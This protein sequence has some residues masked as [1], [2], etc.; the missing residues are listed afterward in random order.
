MY[1]EFKEIEIQNFGSVG[2]IQFVLEPGIT[3]V[4]GVNLDNTNSE[5][6][7]SGKST[8]FSESFRWAIYG[9]TSRKISSDGVI[10][11]V[12]DGDCFVKLKSLIT[13]DSGNQFPVLIER[14]RNHT[15]H[16]NTVQ[17][18]VDGRDETR[19]K[20]ADTQKE[21]ET[22]FRLPITVF[23]C[24]YLM[25]QGMD[26]KFTSMSNI[27]GK[28]YIESLRNVS[29]WEKGFFKARD[30]EKKKLSQRTDLEAIKNQNIAVLSSKLQDLDSKELEVK[31]KQKEITNS[32]FDAQFKEGLKTYLDGL[33]QYESDT[34]ALE[35]RK[36]EYN[37]KK[38]GL[39]VYVN[40]VSKKSGKLEELQN[41]LGGLRESLSST[42]CSSC[43]R[44]FDNV[45]DAVAHS[46]TEI[47]TVN[48]K[49]TRLQNKLR[50]EVDFIKGE[51]AE[52]TPEKNSISTTTNN[53]RATHGELIA[54]HSRLG[55]LKGKGEY[56][57]KELKSLESS[58]SFS[59]T[60]YVSLKT[61]N[62]KV[63]KGV[64]ELN[65]EIPYHTEVKNIFSFTGIRSFLILNDVEFLNERMREFSTCLFSDMVI[66][67]KPTLNKQG[68]ITVLDVVAVMHRGKE[69]PY[70][71][72]SGGEKRRA[73]L[74]I[75]LSIREFV[76]TVYNVSTNLFS[77]DEIFEGLD[78]EGVA[79]VMQLVNEVSD[80]NSSIYVIS[81]RYIDS[82]NGK[83]LSVVKENSITSLSN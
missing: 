52:L 56:L 79:S 25:E 53:L 2:H 7:G 65:E 30:S 1:I 80:P 57:D 75:Q 62:E 63:S 82:F 54:L 34:K 55:G 66:Q 6:N 31:G 71:K 45:H 29:T 36:E 9:D 4:R 11:D 28:N 22:L 19:H 69:R 77:L 13:D 40:E 47:T 32:N 16:K 8:V 70:Q 3:Q 83:I 74:C 39:D 48:I 67:M 49:I 33:K 5:S 58:Y 41:Q 17:L 18:T 15:V 37:T 64:Q 73:D 50:E 81:H 20:V 26:G 14:Y 42:K 44:D 78:R 21:I 68:L 76:R 10:N 51:K 43:G 24:V 38:T 59:K 35:L 61:S 72:I 46:Q 27:E 60:D 12:F 23:S